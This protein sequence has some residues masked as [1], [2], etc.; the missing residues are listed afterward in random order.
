MNE[1]V[2]KG[3][4]RHKFVYHFL[5]ILIGWPIVILRNFSYEYYRI[6]GKPVLILSNHNTDFDPLL[7]VIS[8][9]KHFRFVA[10]ANIMS[11]PIGKIIRF[12]VSP[13]PREKGSEADRTVDL[14]N[15][16]LN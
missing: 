1:D 6:K 4:I 16:N 9:K 2:R 15:E 3:L 11:G 10:S 7:M 12:L 13:N 14:I 8:L 5:R